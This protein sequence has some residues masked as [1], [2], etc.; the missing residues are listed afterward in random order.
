M[1]E[2]VTESEK[3]GDW[4]R[5]YIHFLCF[6]R[7]KKE[8]RASHYLLASLVIAGPSPEN[9]EFLWRTLTRPRS[10]PANVFSSV[11]IRLPWQISF[12]VPHH[13]PMHK[14]SHSSSLNSCSRHLHVLTLLEDFCATNII[15]QGF[16]LK[17]VT[18]FGAAKVQWLASSCWWCIML[19]YLEKLV[20]YELP[21][22]WFWN[23]WWADISHN[24]PDIELKCCQTVDKAKIVATAYAKLKSLKYI[25]TRK[26]DVIVASFAEL[27][28]KSETVRN[29]L[30]K[31]LKQAQC[32]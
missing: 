29:I 26:K 25:Y 19:P 6:G 16:Y 9:S 27:C 17:Y 11:L 7:V 13:V 32:G 4:E 1:S 20:I 5:A 23:S 10:N 31:Q 21:D 22:W 14:H 24:Q 3:E 2:F 12:S 28:K 15:C 18:L 8:I 30:L